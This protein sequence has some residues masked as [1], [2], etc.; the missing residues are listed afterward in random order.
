MFWYTKYRLEILF[1]LL[2]INKSLQ[3]KVFDCFR[4]DNVVIEMNFEGENISLKDALFVDNITGDIESFRLG[5]YNILHN[6]ILSRMNEDY[7]K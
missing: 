4:N 6:I 7:F 5:L 2:L 3:V 1:L